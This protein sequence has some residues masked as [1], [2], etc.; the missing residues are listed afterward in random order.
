M[1]LLA[2]LQL[3]MRVPLEFE[4][5]NENKT[6]THSLSS[7]SSKQHISL[8]WIQFVDDIVKV[9]CVVERER[10]MYAVWGFSGKTKLKHT[11]L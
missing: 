1:L 9:V 3:G 8:M 2:C 11:S 10:G 4:K 7:S 5:S 6:R